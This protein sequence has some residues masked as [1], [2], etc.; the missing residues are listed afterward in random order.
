MGEPLGVALND[1]AADAN[2]DAV[3]EPL[4]PADPDGSGLA[5]SDA[6]PV[7]D[8]VT[9]LL[10]WE[11]VADCEADCDGVMLGVA[12]IDGDTLGV[13]DSEDVTEPDVL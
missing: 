9:G 5:D 4:S 13:S 7:A 8:G 11:G 12:A 3:A 10:A 1:A 6:D 2:W